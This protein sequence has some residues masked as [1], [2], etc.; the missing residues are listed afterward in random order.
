MS[1]KHGSL[2]LIEQDRDNIVFNTVKLKVNENK[3]LF[4]VK[5]NVIIDGEYYV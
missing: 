5:A 2:M 3:V 1:N 4:G